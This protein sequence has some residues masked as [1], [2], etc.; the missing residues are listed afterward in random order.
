MSKLHKDLVKYINH[1]SKIKISLRKNGLYFTSCKVGEAVRELEKM[2][3][4]IFVNKILKI[5]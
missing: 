3:K 1:L 2:E 4:K 5:K